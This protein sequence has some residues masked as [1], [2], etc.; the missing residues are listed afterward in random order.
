MR[1]VFADT[2]WFIALVAADDTLHSAA[3]ELAAQPMRLVTT[4]SIITELAAYLRSG[5]NRELFAS[6]LAT[7]QN[8]PLVEFVRDDERLFDSGAV[9]YTQRADKE[10]SLVDCISFVV[11]REQQLTEALTSDH[12]FEQ[13]GFR[14][15]LIS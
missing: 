8:S 13:A 3:K 5:P 9:L 6:V 2:S 1:R 12:H 14:A 4:S 11:M 15:L 10:W 7:V